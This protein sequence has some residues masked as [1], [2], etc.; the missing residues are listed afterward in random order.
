MR[1]LLKRSH[2]NLAKIARYGE[3]K[4]A[5]LLGDAGIVRNRLRISRGSAECASPTGCEE[6]IRQLR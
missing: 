4:I 1:D 3:V 2:F 6:G 5:A